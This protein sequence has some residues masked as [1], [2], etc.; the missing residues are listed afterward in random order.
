MQETKSTSYKFEKKINATFLEISETDNEQEKR[1]L[2][3]KLTGLVWKELMDS[4]SKSYNIQSF[5]VEITEC[6]K[7]CVKNFSKNQNT[8][9][10]HYLFK[11]LKNELRRAIKKENE[12]S[13]K[14][15]KD[16]VSIY[17]TDE[18]GNEFLLTDFIKNK[19]PHSF[20]SHIFMIEEFKEA[21]RLIQ[22]AI[23][24]EKKL[25]DITAAII[26]Q[27]ILEI[28]DKNKGIIE[29]PDE[30]KSFTKEFSFLNKNIWNNFFNEQEL[31]SQEVV[32]A[33]FN[34]KKENASKIKSRFFEK[35][36]KFIKGENIGHL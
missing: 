19:N 32:A 20:E 8:E 31:P 27:N 10:S 9:F 7:A 18:N 11:A 16:E 5:S 25:K 6:V 4:W 28:L 15:K 1:N 23:N 17:S 26:T 24:E 34:C 14:Q 33:S 13:N 30:I 22:K 3:V 21:L 12:K 2:I 29:T 35:L 36:K